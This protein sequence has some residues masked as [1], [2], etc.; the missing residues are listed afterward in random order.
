MKTIY[1]IFAGKEVLFSIQL[2]PKK[3]A[4]LQQPDEDPYEPMLKQYVSKVGT[5]SLIFQP[6]LGLRVSSKDLS[7]NAI[8]PGHLI[9]QLA[10]IFQSVLQME[11]KYRSNIVMTDPDTGQL[12]LTNQASQYAKQ[13][14]LFRSM[15]AIAPALVEQINGKTDLGV[16]LYLDLQYLGTMSREETVAFIDSINRLDLSTYSLLAGISTKIMDIDAKL[17]K[18]MSKL[19]IR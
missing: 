8:V 14:S 4:Y 5:Q 6:T 7:M 10:G 15:L 12:M 19:G 2:S 9:Y 16:S 1:T 18:I 3:K 11:T 17:D 13:I